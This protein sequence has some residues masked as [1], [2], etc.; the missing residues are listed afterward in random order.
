M[1]PGPA[2]GFFLTEDERLLIQAAASTAG[3]AAAAWE[4]WCGRIDLEDITPASFAILPAVAAHLERSGGSYPLASR[5]RGVRRYAW[6]QNQ[7]T[8]RDLV[9][10][11]HTLRDAGVPAIAHRGPPLAQRYLGDLAAVM[12]DQVDLLIAP[13]DLDR[14]ATSLQGLGWRTA[15]PLPSVLIRP[16]TSA[17][18]FEAPG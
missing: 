17:H 9:T 4:S 16:V 8:L 3:E 6:T 15:S 1:T 10:V 7:V 14:A 18:A 11:Y 13:A 5:L 2:V 12:S